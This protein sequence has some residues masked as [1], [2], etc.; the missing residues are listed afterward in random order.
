MTGGMKKLLIP[1]F[2]EVK[3]R[4]SQSSINKIAQWVCKKLDFRA[5]K[6]LIPLDYSQHLGWFEGDCRNG[7]TLT[8]RRFCKFVRSLEK[9]TQTAEALLSTFWNLAV[10]LLERCSATF[11]PGSR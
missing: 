10:Y 7:V 2:A 3:A 11:N 8:I 6:L 1:A 9:N 4:A 5:R